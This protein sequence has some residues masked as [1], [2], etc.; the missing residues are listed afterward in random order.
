MF[1]FFNGIDKF[2]LLL[3]K[4][5]YPYY[6][7]DDWEK[8]HE[9]SLLEKEEFY[10]NLNIE[11]ITDSVYNHAKRICKDYKFGQISRLTSL[12]LHIVISWCFWKL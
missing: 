12:K 2:L 1:R 9:M 4:G 8:F 10:S 6:F 3:T 5:I 11:N 7:M